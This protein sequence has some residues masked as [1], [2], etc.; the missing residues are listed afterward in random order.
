MAQWVTCLSYKNK[1]LGS[2]PKHPYKIWV[3]QL[4]SVTLALGKGGEDKQIL[5]TR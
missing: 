3:W 4:R 1:D 2:Y 5:G